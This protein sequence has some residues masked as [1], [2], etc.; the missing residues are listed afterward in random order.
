MPPTASLFIYCEKGKVMF[1]YLLST[2][3]LSVVIICNAYA[4]GG[5]LEADG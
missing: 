5:G 3:V 2:L 1:K 4:H